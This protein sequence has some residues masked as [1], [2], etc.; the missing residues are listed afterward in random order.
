MYEQ[1]NKK[2]YDFPFRG[3]QTHRVLYE[4]KTGWWERFCLSGTL[5]IGYI[6]VLVTQLM[7]AMS[8]QHFGGRTY[9]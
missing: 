5:N 7:V 1:T 9:M 6:A 3:W 8:M 4:P 2:L